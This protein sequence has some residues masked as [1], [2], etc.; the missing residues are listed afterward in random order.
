MDRLIIFNLASNIKIY[1]MHHILDTYIKYIFEPGKWKGDSHYLQKI[2][3][4]LLFLKLSTQAVPKYI[5]II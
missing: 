2:Y 3:D 5:L 4:M 1:Q